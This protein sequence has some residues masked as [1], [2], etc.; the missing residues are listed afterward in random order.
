[1]PRK[2]TD[3]HNVQRE[4]EQEW[5]KREDAEDRV[6]SVETNI[7]VGADLAE[8]EGAEMSASRATQDIAQ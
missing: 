6:E 2:G 5:H 7:E 8:V 1:M 3:L 4:I